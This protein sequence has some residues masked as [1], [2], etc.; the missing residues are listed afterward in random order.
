MSARRRTRAVPPRLHLTIAA[1]LVVCLAVPALGDDVPT[2]EEAIEKARALVRQDNQSDAEVYLAELVREEEGPLADNPA[3]LLEAA[4]LTSSVDVCRVYAA[5]AIERTRNSAMLESAHT[6]IG[7][8]YF[9]EGLYLTASQEYTLAA[10]H[11]SVRG[12][13]PADLKRA[14][15]IL[16][17]GDAGAAVDA[18][19]AI[20]VSG[21]TPGEMTPVAEVGL[22]TALLAAGRPEEAAEQFETTASVYTDSEVRPRAL[23]GA[24]ESRRAVGDDSLAVVALQQ[25]LLD[26][27]DSYEAVLAREKLRDYSLPDSTGVLGDT[28]DTTAPVEESQGSPE[29]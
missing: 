20:V 27:P 17:S 25:L 24:A 5:R 12:A 26:H 16:A 19:R 7:D 14:R 8:S 23:A 2:P 18:Y 1:A 15:S 11:G 3:V 21:A 13:G 6:L 29:Q 10:R 22:A 4:R 9:A 28:P